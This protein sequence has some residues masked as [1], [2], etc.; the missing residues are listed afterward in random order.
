MCRFYS[1]RRRRKC[2]RITLICSTSS[3]D[4]SAILQRRGERSARLRLADPV[5]DHRRRV[6]DKMAPSPIKGNVHW[7]ISTINTTGRCDSSIQYRPAA[8]FDFTGIWCTP[9]HKQPSFG[10]TCQRLPLPLP[11]RGAARRR[12]HCFF[13]LASCT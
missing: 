5:L 7:K 12:L 11:T 3:V 8:I 10:C 13:I 4:E 6:H 2:G 9:L 1:G